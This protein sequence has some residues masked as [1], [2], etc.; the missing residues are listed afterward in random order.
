MPGTHSPSTPLIHDEDT[1]PIERLRTI[2][3]CLR[4]PKTG[5]PWDIEQDFASIVPHTIEEAYE[6]ADAIEREDWDELKLELGDLLLQVIFHG[7]M[8]EERGWFNFDDITTAIADKLIVRHP[9]VFGDALIESAAAQTEAWEAQKKQERAARA[10][11]E[12]RH[13]S[14]LDGV[15]AGLPGLTRATK[16]TARA[17]RVG[18]DWPDVHSIFAKLD[19]EIQELKEAIAENPESDACREELGDLLFVCA[20]LARHLHIDAEGAIRETNSKFIRRFQYIETKLR[21]SGKAIE[22]ATLEDMDQLWNEAKQ[23]QKQAE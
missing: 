22:D 18:F 2:M 20:N 5:C 8:A 6:V 3:A 1:T 21:A 16:L 10:A 15:A 14:V 23:A 19:E 13:P 7:R 9:H 4:D 12:G 11:A 17:A